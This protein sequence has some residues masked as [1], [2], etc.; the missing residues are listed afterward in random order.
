M[1][2]SKFFKDNWVITL[3]STMFGVIAGLYLTD[4]YNNSQL[5]EAKQNALSM[6]M[7]EINNNKAELIVYDSI[8]RK[9]YERSS[10][11]F[12]KLN[13]DQEIFIHKDSTKLFEEKSDGII[14]DLKFEKYLKHK[15]TVRVRGEMNMF[16]G[17][18]LALLDLNDVIWQSY[19]QTNYIDITGFDCITGLEE[20]YQ[21][22]RK[23][24][25]VNKDWL[26]QLMHGA[27]LQ[28]DQQLNEFMLLW[29]RALGSNETLIN[30]YSATEVIFEN[31]N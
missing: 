8:C 20:V 18:K 23:N 24:N 6:V 1:K 3:F 12:S 28:G 4:Y 30:A 15:D 10:Y 7:Q 25:S 11:V 22:Q 27:F 5:N 29:S 26:N 9:M 17:S 16:V 21:F 31:C 13:N 19:K 2:L 14:E